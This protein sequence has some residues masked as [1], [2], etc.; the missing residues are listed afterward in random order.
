MNDILLLSIAIGLFVYILLTIYVKDNKHNLL[1]SVSTGLFVFLLNDLFIGDTSVFKKL[2]ETNKEHFEN[3]NNSEVMPVSIKMEKQTHKVNNQKVNKQKVNNQKVNNQKAIK[4]PPYFELCDVCKNIY[5][6]LYQNNLHKKYNN[7]VKIYSEIIHLKIELV[8]NNK[9]TSISLI[10]RI[11]SLRRQNLINMQYISRVPS[12]KLNMI[13]DSIVPLGAN[14][15]VIKFLNAVTERIDKD[16]HTIVINKNTQDSHKLKT[17]N[18][19]F[20]SKYYKP[21]VNKSS[22]KYN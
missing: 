1:I 19:Q 11:L 17:L 4:Y 13:L 14:I 18:E 8:D 7:L 10:P 22:I 15:T 5:H 2:K 16:I 9:G 21:I 6:I 3:L 12:N 20:Y